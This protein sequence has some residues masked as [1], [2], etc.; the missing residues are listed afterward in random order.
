MHRFWRRGLTGIT[1][2]GV[3]HLA[4]CDLGEPP[5]TYATA[6]PVVGHGDI[7]G[8]GDID[9][10]T[11]GRQNLGFEALV[12]DGAGAFQTTIV[13][14]TT[15]SDTC[16]DGAEYTTCRSHRVEDVADIDGDGMADVVVVYGYESNPPPPEEPVD[17]TR[18]VAYLADGTGGFV[19]GPAVPA[20]DIVDVT[21]DGLVDVVTMA[22]PEPGPGARPLH[23]HIGLG[24]G[25][26]GPPIVSYVPELYQRVPELGL[27][28]FQF[29]D[30]NSDGATD[31]VVDG[32]CLTGSSGE[33][34]V[35]GCVDLAFGDSA[36]HFTA[37]PRRMAA[38]PAVDGIF[39]H[40]IDIDNDD[41]L[42][43]VGG[44]VPSDFDGAALA[45]GYSIILGDGDGGLA[46]EV[47]FPTGA[48]TLV[49]G[50]ADFDGDGNVDLL[51]ATGPMDG[52]PRAG[53]IRF[54]DGQGT[55]PQRR[56]VS[57]ASGQVLD[58]D[59]DG[60][61]DLLAHHPDGMAAFLNRWDGR[62]D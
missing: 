3:T 43:I 9:L 45:D 15:T 37:G 40:V 50:A 22:E 28:T 21:G 61:P 18:R 44:R 2:L 39:A 46:D 49:Y 58:L 19:P 34:W 1:L 47:A 60:R 27:A 12:N 48:P 62:P 13:P 25:V 42:D 24:A 11:S 38:D 10:V 33:G 54:G 31:M 53:Y 56:Y 59:A 20:G 57:N 52:A 36:G 14:L 8:D 23:A 17:E 32:A 41:D 51:T 26:F 16:G 29:H 35:R 6:T 4:A 5:T 55:F 30:M 7:D